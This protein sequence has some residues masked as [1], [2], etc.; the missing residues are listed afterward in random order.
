MF[1]LLWCCWL[2]LFLLLLTACGATN[3]TPE[4]MYEAVALCDDHGG[5]VELVSLT[6]YQDE[7]TRYQV[8][9]VD[10]AHITRDYHTGAPQ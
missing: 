4:E 5:L 6:H 7:V 10:S 3:I 1:K 2:L 9:C 8:V